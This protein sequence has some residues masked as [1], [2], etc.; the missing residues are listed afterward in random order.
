[1]IEFFREI[2]HIY[3]HVKYTLLIE[4]PSFETLYLTTKTR[5][6]RN[7]PDLSDINYG[8]YNIIS[9]SLYNDGIENHYLDSYAIQNLF[10][11][12]N[13]NVPLPI[14]YNYISLLDLS[15]QNIND[16]T[17]INANEN[18]NLVKL[19]MFYFY[20]NFSCDTIIL[21]NNYLDISYTEN[22][23]DID[24]II[25]FKTDINRSNVFSSY[26]AN[27]S[28]FSL[29]YLLYDKL[30]NLKFNKS[31]DL[32]F[33]ENFLNKNKILNKLII[34]NDISNIDIIDNSLCFQNLENLKN[35]FYLPDVND[36]D[37]KDKFKK[38]VI[39]DNSLN[40]LFKDNI[41]KRFET[42]TDICNN[43]II[44]NI[45]YSANHKHFVENTQS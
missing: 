42:G 28:D 24:R 18:S 16:I 5:L 35:I 21:N 39:E 45:N 31:G 13:G 2:N 9:N 19:N 26:Y 20:N 36:N 10:N 6:F 12:D 41:D 37:I 27:I 38:L 23:N 1:M 3:N 17:G 11:E 15:N 34:P 32:S 7:I 44:Q 40:V 8:C 22:G 33:N 30:E 43:I 14:I 4:T 25:R 29:N